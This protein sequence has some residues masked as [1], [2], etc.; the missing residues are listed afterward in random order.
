MPKPPEPDDRFTELAN[1]FAQI[2]PSALERQ[3]NAVSGRD[4]SVVDYRGVARAL[5][6]LAGDAMRKP[7]VVMQAQADLL[8]RNMDVFER[9]FGDKSDDPA[10]DAGSRDRRFRH[11]MWS[12]ERFY[13]F[14][15]EA[16]LGNADWLTKQIGNTEVLDDHDKRKVMF[17]TRQLISALSPTNFPLTN[18]QVRDLIE[19]D[20]ADGLLE[21]LENFI[22]DLEKG[23]GNLEISQTDQ[24]AFEVGEDLA[25]TPG[26]VV[27]R[28][29]LMELIQYEASTKRVFEVP[30]LFVPPWIN[31]YYVL[32]L[33]PENSFLKWLVGKG[34]TVF[35]ISWVNPGRDHAE[36]GF[37]D[38][39]REGPL[40][41]IEIVKEVTGAE[42]IN[43][44]GFCIGGILSVCMLAYLS[45][46]GDVPIRSASLLATMVD[47]ADIGECS[48]FVD[49]D[50]IANI[51]R[52]ASEAGYLDGR[53][54]MNMFSML[55][56][57]DLIWNYVVNNYLLGRDPMA[58]DILY[59]NSD[60]TRLPAR[61][62]TDYLRN[63]VMENGLVQ[64]GALVLDG[65]PIDLGNIETPCYFLSTIDDH[66]APW[67]ATYPATQILSGPCEFVLGGSGH[68][69]GIVNPPKRKKYS[70]RTGSDYPENPEDWLA[71][72]QEHKGSWW[73]HW[74]AWLAGH[75]GNKVA[76]R[77]PGSN[78]YPT[79]GRAPGTY[80]LER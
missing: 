37:E 57:N 44:G 47:L 22:A 13:R 27:Y 70:Y 11:K 74:A 62:L 72:A 75:S 65:V 69:A 66:I 63:I 39:M 14:L 67:M 79:L 5:G 28:N 6:K 26:Q 50:Q 1:R 42:R 49:E 4:F 59:W 38:Y 61:M 41:A 24:N 55:R 29:D 18:P 33:Q 32:D 2:L 53:H 23:E 45:K 46:R 76:A 58:F 54:M 8:R 60:S 3:F 80:V 40:Q 64:P 20:G 78:T 21:G 77:K 12:E 10:A 17:Y 31:K 16:Y 9:V 15:R 35:V 51:E 43:L 30:F 34:H 52:H 19:A 25:I 56:E 68:I 36:K 48:V 7:D 71:T 73:L